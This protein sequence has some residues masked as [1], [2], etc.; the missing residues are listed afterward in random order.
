M[1]DP[2]ELRFSRRLQIQRTVV[3]GRIGGGGGGPGDQVTRTRCY[4]SE[5]E[6]N[7]SVRLDSQ[8][9][10]INGRMCVARELKALSVRLS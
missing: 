4:A 3:G 6:A 2:I 7:K 1:A 10:P 5:L 8:H 9:L